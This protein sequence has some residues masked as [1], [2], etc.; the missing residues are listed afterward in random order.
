[1]MDAPEFRFFYCRRLQEIM[2]DEFSPEETFPRIDA[3]FG[4]M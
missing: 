3:A 1:M 4:Y 2:A